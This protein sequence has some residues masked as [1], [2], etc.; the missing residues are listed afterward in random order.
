[1]LRSEPIGLT[2]PLAN[3]ALRDGRQPAH[4]VGA[5]LLRLAQHEDLDRAQ[6]AHRDARA[7]ADH[8]LAD[9]VL[10]QC[11]RSLEAQAGDGDRAELREVHDPVAADDER[12]APAAFA[13]ELHLE[14]VARTD[15]VIGRHR[16]VG[17][18]RK[19]RRHVAEEVVTEWPQ[20][21][22]TGRSCT[23]NRKPRSDGSALSRAMRL[24]F[25]QA[26][27]PDGRR[28]V[29][30]QLP[31]PV[32][33]V[34]IAVPYALLEFVGWPGSRA[35]HRFAR[36]TAIVNSSVSPARSR[37]SAATISIGT[38]CA[39]P[40]SVAV[41]GSRRRRGGCWHG[42]GCL[43]GARLVEDLPLLLRRQRPKDFEL[44]LASGQ[45]PSR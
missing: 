33:P 6:R 13:D 1:M 16:Y 30:R 12:I 8:L 39:S 3:S 35:R 42:L 29:Q 45:P 34:G 38:S 5:R 20:L 32:Q 37:G 17:G 19:R 24:R 26:R 25:G 43:A 31:D 9:A 2:P 21:G 7:H 11:A 28:I 15:D 10:E 23:P 18:R 22:S 14:G 27:E 41:L 36:G 44:L 40:L 4:R